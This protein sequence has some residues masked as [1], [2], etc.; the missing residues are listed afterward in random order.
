M[1]HDIPRPYVAPFDLNFAD[2]VV[3]VLPYHSDITHSAVHH[4]HPI[5]ISG[6]N[7]SNN[8]K[9]TSMADSGANVCITGDASIL[10][11]LVDIDPIPLG[12]AVNSKDTESSLCTKQGFLPIP[13]LNGTYHYQPFLFNPHASETILSPAHVMWSSTSIAKWTQSGSKR[14]QFTDTLTFKNPF[15]V[16]ICTL[17]TATRTR[18]TVRL[19]LD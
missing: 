19:V 17:L 16:Q 10:V 18:S 12:V 6:L 9:P 4:T 1:N 2:D 11:D 3:G 7:S 14:P 5:T 8:V 15:D 13:L